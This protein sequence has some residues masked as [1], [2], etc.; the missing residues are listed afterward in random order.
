MVEGWWPDSRLQQFQKCLCPSV[1]LVCRHLE[2]LRRPLLVDGD[3]FSVRV[4]NTEAILPLSVALVCRHLVEL[5]RPLLVDGDACSVI[6][7][8][9][10]VGLCSSVT[11]ASPNL[12][13]RNP[14]LLFLSK[15]PT[16]RVYSFICYPLRWLCSGAGAILNGHGRNADV[17][18][19]FPDDL[20]DTA[21]WFGRSEDGSRKLTGQLVV[22]DRQ[23]G[24]AGQ[25]SD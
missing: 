15:P 14:L 19:I 21:H 9:T 22:S 7:A 24:E 17:S 25:L 2:E 10:E 18:R 6:V 12:E 4:A 5:R 1:A 20:S 11:L 8:N 3:A 13:R 16:D 23:L